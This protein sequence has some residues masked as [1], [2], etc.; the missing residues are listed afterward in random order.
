MST[1]TQYFELRIVV[2]SGNHNGGSHDVFVPP[3]KAFEKKE[4]FKKVDLKQSLSSSGNK[5]CRTFLREFKNH[6]MAMRWGRRKGDVKSCH[7]VDS[8]RFFRG[9]EFRTADV[10]EPIEAEIETYGFELDRKA[11]L[12]QEIM[13]EEQN[14]EIILDKSK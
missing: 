14:I 1:L 6:E 8:S 12:I 5:G 13:I 3:Q 9:I 2:H 4:V 7:K 10:K 11:Q